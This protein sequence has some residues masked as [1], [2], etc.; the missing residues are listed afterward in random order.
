MLHWFVVILFLVTGFACNVHAHAV[1]TLVVDAEFSAEGRYQ[2]R[3]N[4]DP[5]VFLSSQPTSLPPFPTSWWFEKNEDVLKKTRQQV[6]EYLNTQL[7]LHFGD[8]ALTQQ[9]S[10]AAVE[11]LSSQPLKQ[12][13]LE[14]HLEARS[15]GAIPSTAKNFQLEVKKTCSIAVVL[16]NGLAGEKEKRPQALYPGENSRRFVLPERHQTS[17]RSAYFVIGGVLM[18]LGG[19]AIIAKRRR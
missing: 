11:G 15:E 5:R 12:S 8:T 14:T 19:A 18:I 7:I 10:I 9:W 17:S 16:L 1:P 6:I 2:V 4:L 3:V 13:G